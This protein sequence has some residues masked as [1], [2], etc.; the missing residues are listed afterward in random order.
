MTRQ[1]LTVG[2][3]IQSVAAGGVIAATGVCLGVAVLPASAIGLVTAAAAA[4][5][6][7]RNNPPAPP[8]LPE[9]LELP[10]AEAPTYPVGPSLE[11]LRYEEKIAE[12]LDLTPR[13]QGYKIAGGKRTLLEMPIRPANLLFDAISRDTGNQFFA[14][15]PG[16]DR[17]RWTGF[18]QLIRGH[19]EAQAAAG[20]E[21]RVQAAHPHTGVYGHNEY[22]ISYQELLDTLNSQKI[23]LSPLLPAPFYQGL[24][25]ALLQDRIVQLPYS[26]A[27]KNLRNPNI[28]QFIQNCRRNPTAFGFA[29]RS[30]LE[31]YL[32]LTP[33]Q[34]GAMVV[35]TEDYRVLIDGDGQILAREPGA[36]DAIRLINLSGIRKIQQSVGPNNREIMGYSFYTALI[37]AGEGMV[38][39][40]AVGMGVW[41]GPPEVYWPAFF[42][43]VARGANHLE[44]IFVHPMATHKDFERYQ[45]DA[46]W[47][48]QNDEEALVNFSKVINVSQRNTD[49]VQLAYNLKQQFP[50]K[51]ISLVNASDPDVTL[52]NHVGQA[53]N[54]MRPLT[55]TEEN[56]T[57]MG[58][59]GLCFEWLTGVHQDPHRIIPLEK[60]FASQ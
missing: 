12:I 27:L 13:F 60:L 7:A 4:F 56:Y 3:G 39:F 41:K 37:A 20:R 25:E 6:H 48:Y 43:A 46:M 22:R 14:T 17:F 38:I 5:L 34:I 29:D 23:Y 59:N 15:R 51:V 32:N 40:P 55:T 30:Q 57:A 42:D 49:L 28:Q 52:G 47:R 8:A 1:G 16:P 11:E 26:G 31:R 50:D 21:V 54:A 24:K 58:T 9:P 44:K 53:V 19:I 2:Q 18:T 35:K 45:Q 33:Y 36:R 10:V